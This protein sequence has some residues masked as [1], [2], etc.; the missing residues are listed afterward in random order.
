MARRKKVGFIPIPKTTGEW[1][2]AGIV[3]YL[4][5]DK[6]IKPLLQKLGIQKS[7][8][9]INIEQ[10]SIDPGSPFNVNFWKQAPAGAKLLKVAD[11]QKYAKDIWDSVGWFYDDFEK[12]YSIF[13]QLR[14]QSQVSFLAD[15][16]QQQYKKDLL[17]WLE[18]DLWP[19]DRY[20]T[21]QV[22]LIRKYVKNL[23]KYK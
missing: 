12:V 20:S 8:A 18:G 1:V 16:F 3:V 19:S 10:E 2:A 7:E 13:K 11:A 22:E 15:T 6:V 21:D 5:Y 23:P 9:E 14:F 4:G 17:A